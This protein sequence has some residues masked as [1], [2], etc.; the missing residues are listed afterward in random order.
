ML[1]P[2]IF[3]TTLDLMTD[4]YGRASGLGLSDE[5]Y[6]PCGHSLDLVEFRKKLPTLKIRIFQEGD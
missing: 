6:A 5:P 2:T 4:I 1:P 3:F